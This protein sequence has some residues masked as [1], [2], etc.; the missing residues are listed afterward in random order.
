MDQV[1]PFVYLITHMTKETTRRLAEKLKKLMQAQVQ[2][3]SDMDLE[4]R[5]TEEKSMHTDTK[6]G[7]TFIDDYDT[8]NN[9]ARYKETVQQVPLSPDN[10]GSSS[11]WHQRNQCNRGI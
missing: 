6:C 10:N 5:G 8:Q 2:L 1:E 11:I 9:I 4:T 3:P 7:L